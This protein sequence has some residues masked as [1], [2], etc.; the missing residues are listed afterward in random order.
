[1]KY[2]TTLTGPSCSGKTTLEDMLAR[3][4]CGKAVSTT[5]RERRPGERDGVDYYFVNE[6][7]FEEMMKEPYGFIEVVNFNGNWYGVTAAEIDRLHARFDHVI[8]VVEPCG[9]KQIHQYFKGFKNITLRQVFL[10][11][12]PSVLAER[13]L[14]RFGQESLSN[15]NAVQTYA[16]RMATMMSTERGWVTE[17]YLCNDN[18]INGFKYDWLLEEFNLVNRDEVIARILDTK[19]PFPEHTTLMPASL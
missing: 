4:G 14:Q 12:R 5:T 19:T 3:R 17:A 18:P 10:T 1:M 15:V 8:L 9:A 7:A 11:N 6:G 13:F 16:K 2:L